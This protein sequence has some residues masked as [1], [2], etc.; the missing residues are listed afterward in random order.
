MRHSSLLPTCSELSLTAIF[1]VSVSRQSNSIATA[2][3]ICQHS[4]P[5]YRN[6]EET[7]ITLNISMLTA[8]M[9]YLKKIKMI[10]N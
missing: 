10:S 7:N 8:D 4:S 5:K 6:M 2:A 1:Q 3:N 9:K